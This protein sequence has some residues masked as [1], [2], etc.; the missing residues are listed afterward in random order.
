MSARILVFAGSSRRASLNKRLAGVVAAAVDAAGGKATLIDLADYDMPL[1]QGDW[2]NDYGAPEP[3]RRLSS[4]IAEHDGLALASPENNASVS[5]LMKN[6]LDW[7][8]RVNGGQ[9]LQGKVALLTAASPGA[10]GGLME[11]YFRRSWY[12]RF[13]RSACRSSTRP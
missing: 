3:A 9:V 10:L 6:T 12:S 8:S 1:Y 4:L 2:E 13:V 7:V 11:R 5:A